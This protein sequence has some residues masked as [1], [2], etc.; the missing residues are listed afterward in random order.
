[1]SRK[2]QLVSSEEI[3]SP[4]SPE[5]RELAEAVRS[6]IR[7]VEPDGNS[8]DT[9]IS[10]VLGSLRPCHIIFGWALNMALRSPLSEGY[11]RDLPVAELRQSSEI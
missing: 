4:L 10:A 5:L 9:G 8:W 11:C 3:L 1:M 7:E 2:H 6:L